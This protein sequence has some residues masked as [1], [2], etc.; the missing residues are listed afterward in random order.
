MPANRAGI[1]IHIRKERATQ[2]CVGVDT[3]SRCGDRSA[4]I[5]VERYGTFLQAPYKT[6]SKSLAI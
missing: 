6:S 5:C 2:L 1:N 4:A 3:R